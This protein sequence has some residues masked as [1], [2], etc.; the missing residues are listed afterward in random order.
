MND[1]SI[2]P[3]V[4]SSLYQDITDDSLKDEDNAAWVMGLTPHVRG[5]WIERIRWIRSVDRLAEEELFHRQEGHDKPCGSFS[6]F[7]DAWKTL[8]KT[9]RIDRLEFGD[10]VLTTIAARWS[11]SSD[12][13]IGH[14]CTQSWDRYLDAIRDYH[15]PDL[16]LES[17]GDHERMLDRM[18]GS[19][20]QIL[21]FLRESQQ[22]M[23]ASLGVLDQFYNNLRDL[24]ED[25][26]QGICYFPTALLEEFGVPR[27][28]I[29]AGTAMAN[30]GYRSL[31]AFWLEDYLPRLE[32]LAAPALEAETFHASWQVLRAWSQWRYRRIR[33]AFEDCQYDYVGFQQVYWRQVRHDLHAWVDCDGAELGR[34]LGDGYCLQSVRAALR[35][36]TLSGPPLQWWKRLRPAAL[37]RRTS[38]ALS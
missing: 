7:Y 10:E 32:R 2:A 5:E 21:P 22:P 28:E 29:L 18:A 34:L 19:F 8:L 20:F 15:T 38:L 1:R 17:I 14:P 4:G 6:S 37:Q 25:A 33:R 30:P 35:P 23:A 9:G 3:L 13:I 36:T 11:H 24:H 16:A 31:M 27:S 12:G 26:R